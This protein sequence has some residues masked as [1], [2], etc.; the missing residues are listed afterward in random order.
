MNRSHSSGVLLSNHSQMISQL[1]SKNEELLFEEGASHFHNYIAVGGTLVLTNRRLIF[2]SCS[3]NHYKHEIMINLG[4]IK[5]VEFF[6]TLFMNPNGLA[7]LHGDGQVDNFIVDDKKA[8]KGRIEK[9][10]QHLA[11]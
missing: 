8:W 4:Q 10:L 7:L 11:S 5:G 3:S 2:V 9:M 1:L 6:K